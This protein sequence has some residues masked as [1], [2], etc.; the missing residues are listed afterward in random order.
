MNVL[1]ILSNWL[2]YL[3]MIR[4]H[5]IL[6][7]RWFSLKKVCF[8]NFSFFILHIG[9]KIMRDFFMELFVLNVILCSALGFFFR[10]TLELIFVLILFG[11]IHTFERRIND[12]VNWFNPCNILN[13]TFLFLHLILLVWYFGPSTRTLNTF[14][15]LTSL[16]Y[17]RSLSL[18]VTVKLSYQMQTL[19]A[20][21]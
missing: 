1:L 9:L 15:G 4:L 13:F 11:L 2:A 5:Q 17:W 8:A 16:L 3:H 19:F 7:I 12:M 18:F 21:N 6:W 14:V 20:I 10:F